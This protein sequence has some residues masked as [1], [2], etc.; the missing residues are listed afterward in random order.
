[1]VVSVDSEGALLDIGLAA[2]IGPGSEFMPVTTSG[3]AHPVVR[4]NKSVG[5]AQSKAEISPPGAVSPTDIIVLT[6]WVPAARPTLSFYA[7]PLNLS[8]AEIDGVL[9]TLRASGL[10]LVADPSF[11][12][13]TQHLFWDG[14][15][16][17]LHA[18]STKTPAG[19]VQPGK[20]LVLGG[21]LTAAELKRAPAASAV[22]FDPPLPKESA[23]GLFPSPGPVERP[24]AAAL[25]QD[26]ARAMYSIGGTVTRAGI[27]YAWFKVSDLDAEVQIPAGLGDG[28]S[29]GSS[30]PLRTDWTPQHGAESA[31]T[32][33]AV[34]LA[35]LNG[36]LQIG[37]SLTGQADFP[38]Q[39][40]LRSTV[41]T[42]DVADNGPTHAG[43]YQLDLVLSVRAPVEPRWVYVLEID[44]Q[45][46]GTLLW[47]TEGAPPGKFPGDKGRLDRI[48]LPDSKFT[49]Q[50]PYGM[51]RYLLLTTSAPL[52][53]PWALEF[54]GVVTRGGGLKSGAPL[55]PLEELLDAT[56]AGT[57][58]AGRLTPANWSIQTLHTQSRGA[59][60]PPAAGPKQ[61]SP[62]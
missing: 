42:E 18:H 5:L 16:W 8:H 30:Y 12:S 15:H 46:K 50:P 48:T 49:V 37:T 34:Q 10:K 19:Q 43:E 3:D 1:M 39:L 38:Y 25:I 2:D 24:S 27:N 36:W 44:C 51:D 60:T 31:L 53:D 47:P 20:S 57:R 56:S 32:A 45:G 11:E 17:I 40:A 61:R 58:G 21:R 22:W 6:K 52:A 23:P 7:G 26:R 4:V 62:L 13:W 14:A 29:P 59:P 28:C 55:D 35:R 41:N 54:T 9:E 33:S